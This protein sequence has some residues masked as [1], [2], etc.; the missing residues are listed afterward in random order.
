MDEREIE[1][2]FMVSRPP[3]SFD[4][5]VGG[6]TDAPA[7]MDYIEDAGQG[8]PEDSAY[9]SAFKTDIDRALR[10]LSKREATILRYRFG[11]NETAC[12]SLCEIGE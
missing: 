11:L 7:L 10:N 5:V 3:L 1:R 8:G 12:V 6:G 4:E 2:L 9:H